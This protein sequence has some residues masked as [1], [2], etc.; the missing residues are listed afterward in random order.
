MA[1]VEDLAELSSEFR[2]HIFE[3]RLSFRRHEA[4]RFDVAPRRHRLPVQRQQSDGGAVFLPK[5]LVLVHGYKSGEVKQ[6]T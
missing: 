4:V 5:S 1:L 3:A 2:W 6:V